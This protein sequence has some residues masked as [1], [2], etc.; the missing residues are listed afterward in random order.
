MTLDRQRADRRGRPAGHRRRALLHSARVLHRQRPPVRQATTAKARRSTWANTPSRQDCGQGQPPGGAR[1]G[2]LHDRHG[3]QLRRGRDGLLRPAVRQREQ[4][5]VEPR[6][7]QLRQLAGSTARPRITCRRCSAQNRGDVVL[8]TTVDA[9]PSAAA[10]RQAAP[11]ASAPGPPRPSSRTSRSREGDKTLFASRLRQR[12]QGLE[13]VARPVADPRT[14][15]CGRRQARP[16][17]ASRPAIPTGATTR[18]ASRPA[19]SAAPKAFSSCSACGTTT[20]GSGGTWAVGATSST[21]WSS[22]RRRQVDAGRQVPGRI[23]TGRWYDI[24]IEL[25]GDAIRCYLD[26]KLIHDVVAA[27]AKPLYAVASRVDA[28]GEVIL[29]V[30]NVSAVAQDTDDRACMACSTR[31]GGKGHRADVG[32][33]G[34]R[35]LVGRAD[36]GGAGLSGDQWRRAPLPPRLPAPLR[37]RRTADGQI[38]SSRRLARGVV[39]AS[40][41]GCDRATFATGR[42]SRLCHTLK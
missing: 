38:V 7:D 14:A 26:G 36:Q 18:L 5:A 24:R 19:S 33:P 35:E 1:R 29:K 2:R 17:A 23:E 22:A 37:N 28:S 15:P 25:S 40:R 11:S 27:R 20:T 6:P 9:R 21:A 8:P 12:Q 10:S 16:T 31:A 39:A 34:G 41:P 4:Q 42:R 3:A 32:R 30:V 13:A